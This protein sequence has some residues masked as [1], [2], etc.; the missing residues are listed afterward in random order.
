M[1]IQ[2]WQLWGEDSTALTSLSPATWDMFMKM[3]RTLQKL[4]WGKLEVK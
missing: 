2:Q 3:G 4:F 1:K